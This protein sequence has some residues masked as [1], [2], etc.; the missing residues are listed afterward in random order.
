M[1]RLIRTEFAAL[2]R[3]F[4]VW[5]AVLLVVGGSVVAR[6][7]TWIS[8][9]LGRSELS[10]FLLINPSVGWSD[11]AIP[12]ALLADLIV[13]AYAFGRDF[14]DGE[15]DLSLTAPVRREAVVF[16]RTS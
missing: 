6:V 10:A 12:L 1:G 4:V 7:L 16:A 8:H 5:L 9:G 3:S 2:R 13:T 15:I 14:E 11:V